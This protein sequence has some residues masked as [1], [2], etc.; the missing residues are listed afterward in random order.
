[1]KRYLL[2]E[3]LCYLSTPLL[4]FF[5]LRMQ[6]LVQM[7]VFFY[8]PMSRLNCL[9][10]SG[11]RSFYRCT[12]C[13]MWHM[14]KVFI[15]PNTMVQCCLCLKG[16]KPKECSWRRLFKSNR[17]TSFGNLKI[18]KTLMKPDFVRNLH[19]SIQLNPKK[20]YIRTPIYGI[21]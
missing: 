9:K 12:A 6:D 7:M 2:P 17:V 10:F 16:R 11:S 18:S 8:C 14:M 1:M 4:V 13:V 19:F 21:R 5:F 20:W 15:I 3:C